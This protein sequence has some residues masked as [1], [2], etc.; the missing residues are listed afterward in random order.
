[1]AAAMTG[2]RFAASQSQEGQTSVNDSCRVRVPGLQPDVWKNSWSE[3]LRFNQ[4]TSESLGIWS[5]KFWVPTGGLKALSEKWGQKNRTEN[6]TEDE[7]HK[8]NVFGDNW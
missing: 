2:W 5:E 7:G 6:F 4:K 8:G 3:L 1:M